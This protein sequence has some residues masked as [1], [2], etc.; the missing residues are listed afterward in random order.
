M[1]GSYLRVGDH[2]AGEAGGVGQ[3][4]PA[5][6]EGLA[7]LLQDRVVGGVTG[8][9]ERQ[10]RGGQRGTTVGH[11]A[12]LAPQRPR[13]AWASVVSPLAWSMAA[14]RRSASLG[15]PIGGG[16]LDV[17]DHDAPGLRDREDVDA[18][19]GDDP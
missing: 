1:A 3:G 9:L 2:R 6:P 10:Q 18:V 14:A 13:S 7:G 16:E 11:G 17:G 8:R 4:G 19:V 5:G 15:E 12:E